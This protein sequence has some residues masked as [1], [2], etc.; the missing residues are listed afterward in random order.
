MP[1]SENDIT[2]S[3][4]FTIKDTQQGLVFGMPTL[5]STGKIDG[6]SVEDIF[7]SIVDDKTL[8]TIMKNRIDTDK[9]A[10]NILI[11]QSIGNLEEDSLKTKMIT[12]NNLQTQ[13][14][15]LETNFKKNLNNSNTKTDFDGVLDDEDL[16]KVP[17]SIFETRLEQLI[18]TYNKLI[19]VIE[20]DDLF[21]MGKFT[22]QNNTFKKFSKDNFKGKDTKTS[23]V[24]FL[25]Y[26]AKTFMRIPIVLLTASTT[27]NELVDNSGNVV[28]KDKYEQCI[29]SYEILQK[30]I[31][32][33]EIN[34]AKNKKLLRG[35]D[36]ISDAET[37]YKSF[38]TSG[39]QI[40]IDMLCFILIQFLKSTATENYD[41]FI[42]AFCERMMYIITYW[43]SKE[44]DADKDTNKI[45]K[46][47]ELHFKKIKVKLD[48][49]TIDRYF[50]SILQ[51]IHNTN[52]NLVTFVKV[53]KGRTTIDPSDTKKTKNDN[54]TMNIRYS[55]ISDDNNRTKQTKY[56]TKDN[57][58]LE[59][60]YDDNINSFYKDCDRVDSQGNL[61]TIYKKFNEKCPT[62]IGEP[63]YVT[64][65]SHELLATKVEYKHD[66]NLGPF[67][68]I[69]D[70]TKLNKDIAE[71]AIFKEKI[72]NKL[73]GGSPVS[74]IGYGASGSGKT[75]VL[76]QLAAPNQPVQPGILMYLSDKLG[77]HA[78]VNC[79]VQI[80]EF[81][82]V[83]K[84][85]PNEINE[86]AFVGSYKYENKKWGITGY[87]NDGGT[88][89]SGGGN[90]FYMAREEYCTHGDMFKD[91]LRF[92]DFQRIVR[93][94][95]NNPVSS[96]THVII[97]LSYYGT[98]STDVKKLFI[99]DLAGVENAFE[100]E[101]IK[102]DKDG[103]ER[104][105]TKDTAVTDPRN[106]NTPSFNNQPE[107]QLSQ[108]QKSSG[109]S[110]IGQ[111]PES[112]NASG[113]G[114]SPESSGASSIEYYGD[115]IKFIEKSDF[116][117]EINSKNSQFVQH[118]ENYGIT[119]MRVL[120]TYIVKTFNGIDNDFGIKECAEK[121]RTNSFISRNMIF[122][123]GNYFNAVNNAFGTI[124]DGETV[125]L[126]KLKEFVVFLNSI[127]LNPE[128][129]LENVTCSSV[130]GNE[131][132]TLTNATGNI[133]TTK[134]CK[135]GYTKKI[136]N[137]NNM[138]NDLME[139]T[140]TYNARF[141][142]AKNQNIRIQQQDT[143]KNI[144]TILKNNKFDENMFDKLL[145]G[146]KKN[147]F[148]SVIDMKSTFN[149][150]DT[151]GNI[152]NPFN[153]ESVSD[154]T[155]PIFSTNIKTLNLV[156]DN[157]PKNFNLTIKPVDNEIFNLMSGNINLGNFNIFNNDKSDFNDI[158]SGVNLS[159]KYIVDKQ[160]VIDEIDKTNT[161][162][163]YKNNKITVN[164]NIPDI[165]NKY[166]IKITK[167]QIATLYN[168]T[169]IKYND[170]ITNLYKLKFNNQ[171]PTETQIKAFSIYLKT[172]FLKEFDNGGEYN[173]F[174]LQVLL[175]QFK[176]HP[177]KKVENEDINYVYTDAILDNSHQIKT[178]FFETL[179][180]KGGGSNQIQ[181]FGGEVT[182]ERNP[183]QTFCDARTLEGRYINKFLAEMRK[184]I[185][186][187]VATINKR[188]GMPSFFSKCL[189]LQ[190]NPEF[191]E[192]LGIDNY[193]PIP[194]S[195]QNESYGELV[196]MIKKYV[197]NESTNPI[198]FCVFCILNLSEPPLVRDPPPV[199][200]VDLTKLQQL[201][202]IL[203]NISIE[204]AFRELDPLLTSI[205]IEM[206]RIF[207]SDQYKK[208][209][210][211]KSIENIVNT[212]DNM[213]VNRRSNPNDK[214][215]TKDFSDLVKTFITFISNVNAATPIGT[216]LFTDSVAKNF[217][218]V[219]TCNAYQPL[220]YTNENFGIDVTSSPVPST[221]NTGS[222]AASDNS[223]ASSEALTEDEQNARDEAELNRLIE[224]QRNRRSG[225]TRKTMY[226]QNNHTGKF[227]T[228]KRK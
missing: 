94:T 58:I 46:L 106:C 81:G 62:P 23:L 73:M 132:Y 154:T 80:I 47:G 112:S 83:G 172:N 59:F 52:D 222:T 30:H 177:M 44:S 84:E 36:K 213:L 160:T 28:D 129:S 60:R 127:Q 99:C 108:S 17:E 41:Y 212:V 164:N 120:A 217:V 169:E 1:K 72:L 105:R 64:T 77:N 146:E 173:K 191:K 3:Y 184:G 12:E 117:S 48:D 31:F 207:E 152:I 74:I 39:V 90:T 116:I 174:Q 163:L 209:G 139:L 149:S 196:D 65:I 25:F 205:Q 121:I 145:N 190:C 141:K 157:S 111:N 186:K 51:K 122:P 21:T 54:E 50:A 216:V 158:Y 82:E 96:R 133:S 75:S 166:N 159:I 43:C 100:C 88:L 7:K 18:E 206:I 109:A 38:V 61:I 194:V 55:G 40:S 104:F 22:V 33:T 110:S 34:D 211:N 124:T 225:G 224:A 93:K 179:N 188:K 13:L 11:A 182:G 180:S 202:Q 148:T 201:Y 171:S 214:F 128:L 6:I 151:H 123:L 197:G 87:K 137:Y 175:E 156:E 114:Q 119:P 32:P 185:P 92:M 53:R 85:K 14:N 42:I 168:N 67:T 147:I 115:P 228:T 26:V 76:I 203:D 153:D 178:S 10:T 215:D 144:K 155:K 101:S 199:P 167:D 223:S 143:L 29:A 98:T 102:D 2:I 131:K 226:N 136:V 134:D 19:S 170:L 125:R 71:S 79:D 27:K 219:N 221:A 176:I 150:E 103:R 45:T 183:M 162:V 24:A 113:I 91:I 16:P 4:E 37:I 130:N 15:T 220:D 187:Y 204:E 57:T 69:Y 198:V 210:V 200:Y 161:C 142:N 192:C 70:E 35:I 78:Y 95:P 208:Q 126:D 138:L 218:D 118:Q 135:I 68:H 63:G 56:I 227:R 140:N 20:K 89:N 107:P 195:T 86:R 189:P 165:T 181:Q 66:F 49:N 193:T 5:L 97:S 8:Q 9:G